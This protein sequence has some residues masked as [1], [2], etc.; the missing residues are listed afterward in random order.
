MPQNEKL[1]DVI[2]LI[3]DI[4]HGK[5]FSSYEIALRT[6]TLLEKLI[7]DVDWNNARE[8]MDKIKNKIKQVHA[9]L[10]LEVTATNI[11]RHVMKVIREE[12]K[13]SASEVIHNV[14]MV[15]FKIIF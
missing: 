12:F 6:E 7:A 9:T 4:K 5:L 8:L 1:T 3:S 11:M 2:K 10:P 15:K 14:D 13:D